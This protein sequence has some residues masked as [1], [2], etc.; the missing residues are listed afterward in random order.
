MHGRTPC[1]GSVPPVASKVPTKAAQA[2]PCGGFIPGVPPADI[3]PNQRRGRRGSGPSAFR[4]TRVWR[5]AAPPASFHSAATIRRNRHTRC[6]RK[7]PRGDSGRGDRQN[8]RAVCNRFPRRYTMASSPKAAQI[9]LRAAAAARH[10]TAS[11]CHP[12]SPD[13]FEPAAG[14]VRHASP[15]C[16]SRAE[17]PETDRTPPPAPGSHV[18]RIDE[19]EQSL[20]A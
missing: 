15:R 12:S 17:G 1:N 2:A 14:R 18:E 5:R 9:G 11:P 6:D 13:G 4:S 10:R 19:T 8:C 20:D 3:S 16:A 7:D